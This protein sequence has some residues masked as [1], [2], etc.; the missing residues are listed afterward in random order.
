MSDTEPGTCPF[1]A[2]DHPGDTH[3]KSCVIGRHVDFA[4]ARGVADERARVAAD[5]IEAGEHEEVAGFTH[6]RPDGRE[7][8][9]LASGS[10]CTKCGARFPEGT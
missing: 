7:C 1:C 6:L 8:D 10:I 3:S 4:H 2:W 9:Y 5:R